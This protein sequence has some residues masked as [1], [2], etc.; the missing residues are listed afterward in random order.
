MKKRRRRGGPFHPLLQRLRRRG[1][2][3]PAGQPL[4]RWIEQLQWPEEEVKRLVL[5]AIESVEQTT[6]G[7]G[8]HEVITAEVR[9]ANRLPARR[10]PQGKR[11]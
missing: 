11:N 2:I 10:L 7:A 8:T 9:R 3:R 6:Y 5:A 4:A 1:L